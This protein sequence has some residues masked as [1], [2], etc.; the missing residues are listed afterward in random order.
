MGTVMTSCNAVSPASSA[1]T[2]SMAASTSA[3]R[4]RISADAIL[5]LRCQQT[6][7][8]QLGKQSLR[9]EQQKCSSIEVVG[10]RF[11]LRSRNGMHITTKYLPNPIFLMKLQQSNIKN[12]IL[13][14][15]NG[16]SIVPA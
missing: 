12:T 16:A 11:D 15:T 6:T 8:R 2:M 10:F 5:D 14:S 13:N 7:Y 3:E 9:K 4:L 1:S